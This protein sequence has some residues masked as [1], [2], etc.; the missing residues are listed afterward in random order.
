MEVL[1]DAAAALEYCQAASSPISPASVVSSRKMGP[2]LTS[3]TTHD[4]HLHRQQPRRAPAPAPATATATAA[5]PARTL[6]S[7][8]HLRAAREAASEAILSSGTSSPTFTLAPEIIRSTHLASSPRRGDRALPGGADT[9]VA[10]CYMLGG[11]SDAALDR[12]LCDWDLSAPR[13][14]RVKAA[15]AV[16]KSRTKDLIVELSPPLRRENRA[17]NLAAL[18]VCEFITDMLDG[19]VAREWKRTVRS[20]DAEIQQL[21]TQVAGLQDGAL[22]PSPCESA[23]ASRVSSLSDGRD[24]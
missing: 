8:A 14:I 6:S 3:D 21:R 20:R 11:T 9:S 1:I 23:P 13:A 24:G 17:E 10:A 18:R 16:Y 4:G 22:S 5:A 7:A 2:S 15:E 19:H 12:I